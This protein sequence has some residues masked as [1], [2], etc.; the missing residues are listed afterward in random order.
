MNPDTAIGH[1]ERVRFE[2]VSVDGTGR[3]ETFEADIQVEADGDDYVFMPVQI[4]TH[5]NA[6]DGD[7]FFPCMN[8]TG[9]QMCIEMALQ[10]H[11]TNDT[12]ANIYLAK[13]ADD[14]GLRPEL[15]RAA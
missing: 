13:M 5:Q 4:Y 9:A 8:D 2:E 11:V 12:D 15:L 6:P 14:E 3:I 7:G 10:Y 1:L